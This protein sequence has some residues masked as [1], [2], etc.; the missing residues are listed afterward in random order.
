[1]QGEVV[2]A[3]EKEPEGWNAADKF[4]VVLESAGLNA[5]ELSAY[6]RERGLFPV[7]VSR[8]R[9]AA[10]TR[11][12]ASVPEALDANAKPV[13]TMAEQKQLEKLRTL[14]EA[15]AALLLLRK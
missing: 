11:P 15:A 12:L 9:Q 13:L 7:Q 10:H 6:C 2:P 5:T 1:M 4:M 8:C 14:A 3:S